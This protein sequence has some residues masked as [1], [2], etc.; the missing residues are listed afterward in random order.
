[1]K[2]LLTTGPVSGTV[3]AIG[4]KS[5]AHR[6]LICAA[7]ADKPT[8]VACEG[9]SQ[10]IEA[11]VRCLTALGAEIEPWDEGVY[12]V[13]PLDRGYLPEHCDLDC[14]ESGSTLRFLLPVVAA[15][16]AN[17]SFHTAGRL[18][19]RP[20]GPLVRELEAH[21]CTVR[22]GTDQQL[23]HVSG[24][25]EAGDYHLPGD[26][27]SQFVSGLLLGLSCL[28]RESTV[29][30]DGPLASAGYVDLTVRA[31]RAFAAAPHEDG[32]G[33][34][35][36]D[37]L[38]LLSPGTVSVE[39]DWSN[40]A[41]WLC[42]GALGG[43]GI[44]VTGLDPASAQGDRAIVRILTEM[45]A[46]V[47]ADGDA[48]TVRP[49]A[50]RPIALDADQVPDLVPVVAALA[51]CVPG[52]SV[53][54]NAGRLRLKESDRLATTAALLR[55]LGAE[56]QEEGDTLVIEG[57]A[58]LDGGPVPFAGDHRLAMAAAVAARACKA[59]VELIDAEAVEKSYP[60][61]WTV[62]DG[63]TGESRT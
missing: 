37:G 25:L 13:T 3:R 55:A 21:G 19:Q 20:L 22:Y 6:L 18:F 52:R 17:A 12:Q 48:V 34:Y 29:T 4:S 15:L 50:L 5:A 43:T 45:G 2:K 38:G 10:D 1:M 59:P 16:G 46:Q 54:R 14:G 60:S 8:W 27:S 62:L 44:T 61:F 28:M 49:G 51:A 9:T 42:M 57:R 40:A 63:L 32:A 30:V 58:Q 53:V 39:G 31:L 11:T 24:R 33:H 23:I 7:V 47:T 56:A 35:R 41:P 26:V 36:L